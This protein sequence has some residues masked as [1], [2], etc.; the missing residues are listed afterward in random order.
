VG[1]STGGR[2]L[3]ALPALA[4]PNF[5]RTV[6]LVL[7]HDDDGALGIVL[8]RPTLTSVSDVLRGWETV[9][10]APTLVFGGGPVEPRAVVGLAIARPGH[11]PRETINDRIRTVDPTADPATVAG[12]VDGARLFAGYAGW[13]PGQLED[14]LEDGAWTVVDAHA[15]DIVSTDPAALWSRVLGRQRGSLRLLASFPDD[16]ALN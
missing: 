4:D 16:P 7:E 15:D 5:E 2:L 14:E 3:V 8:N 12:E 10:A 11:E 6:V 9:V 13:A 1:H